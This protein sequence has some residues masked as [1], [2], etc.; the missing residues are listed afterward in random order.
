[1]SPSRN[2]GYVRRCTN[3]RRLVPSVGF[4]IAACLGS[5]ALADEQ[6]ASNDSS[7]PVLPH[8]V[9]LHGD[10]LS[11]RRSPIVV[12]IER[13]EAAVVNIQGNKTISTTT[14][15]AGTV[16]QEVSGMGT[17]VVIDPRGYI[18]TNL[19]VV[20]DVPKIEV[21]LPTGETLIAKLLNYDHDTDLA[22]IK[23]PTKKELPVAP[24]G[25]SHDLYRGETVIAI[26][27]PFG[28]QNTVTQGII[29]A[30]HR[31]VPVNG[32]QEYRDLIQTSADINPG[33]SGGPLLNVNGEVI[34]INVAVRVG[35][36]GIGFA[37]PIDE[38][39]EVMSELVQSNRSNELDHGL[40]LERTFENHVARWQ[41]KSI[42]TNDVR[43]T[44]SRRT[45]TIESNDVQEESSLRKGDVLVSV[46]GK[47]TP[48]RLALEL[49]MLGAKS[50]DQIELQVE[51]DGQ[52]IS[53]HI[54]LEGTT[55]VE[56]NDDSAIEDDRLIA[57]EQIGIRVV[58]VDAE[59]V[60]TS[61]ES[62]QGGLKIT[63][64]RP[65]SPAA[66]QKLSIGD[67]IVGVMN[68]QTPNWKALNWVL[69]NNDLTRASTAKIYIVRNQRPFYVPLAVGK[70]ANV[71]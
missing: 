65:G 23:I 7:L 61:T 43:L 18:I 4:A 56:E 38:A 37:I 60:R 19:H 30:L 42:R 17:G 21:T 63:E 68:W 2:Q 67:T 48:P 26:G 71:R 15:G 44:S 1:M 66:V 52:L 9:D 57:W 69:T 27:N 58:E 20:Q 31:D 12:A 62:Y 53:Q 33:N 11:N 35:A 16:K 10:L 47:S 34:G 22:L 46:A 5:V 45:Q 36:Q 24:F 39:I 14:A 28:Y 3:I 32:S 51:R 6:P 13:A 70:A 29:S 50:G 40:T 55:K 49:A 8:V 59:A 54:A 64:I 41:V 25:T